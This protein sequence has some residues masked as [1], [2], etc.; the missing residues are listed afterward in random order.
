MSR[1]TNEQELF[2]GLKALSDSAFPKECA[3]CGRVN[4]SPEDFV[5]QS[6]DLGGRSG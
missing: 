6:E 3:N 4:H 1:K 2:D 5:A